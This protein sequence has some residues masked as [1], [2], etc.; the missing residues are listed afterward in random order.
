MKIFSVIALLA[1]SAWGNVV[2]NKVVF[3]DQNNNINAPEVVASVTDM[4]TNKT[5]IA[6]AKAA[7]DAAA[8]AARE[9]TNLVSATI[10]KI[11]ENEFVVYR[12]GNTDSLGVLV[13]LPEGTLCRVGDFRPNIATDGQGNSQHE[14]TYYTTED[15]SGVIPAIKHANSLDDASFTILDTTV[16]WGSIAGSFTDSAG[17]IFGYGYNVKFWL[18]SASQGFFIIYLDADAASGDGLTF[19]IVGGITGGVTEEV[20]VGSDTLVFKGGLLLEVRNNDA[21]E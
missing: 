5:E 18:P 21:V 4:A 17:N 10:N 8:S 16:E 1:V 7:A 14:I 13:A 2:S 20:T 12:Y 19:D 11:V 3:I 9:G 15:A 6:I